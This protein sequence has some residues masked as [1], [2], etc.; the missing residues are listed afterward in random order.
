ME[1][2]RMFGKLDVQEVGENIYR[3][4]LV[5]DDFHDS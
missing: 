4:D 3:L 1:G 2:E 5:K